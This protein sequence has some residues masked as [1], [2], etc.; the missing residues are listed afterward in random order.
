MNLKKHLSKGQHE[1]GLRESERGTEHRTEWPR[2]GIREGTTQSTCRECKKRTTAWVHHHKNKTASRTSTDKTA[3][4][5]DPKPQNRGFFAKTT[6][7]NSI[8]TRAPK[9]W[10]TKTARIPKQGKPGKGGKKRKNSGSTQGSQ[11]TYG[12]NVN[13]GK[14]G[15]QPRSGHRKNRYFHTEGKRGMGPTTNVV[16]RENLN[17]KT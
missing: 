14:K 5:R 9:K 6:K 13:G 3:K 10:S 7:L 4:S 1:T 17:I 15:G 11:K 8:G 12:N 2:M 16:K